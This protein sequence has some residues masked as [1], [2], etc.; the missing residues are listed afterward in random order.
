MILL[1]RSFVQLGARDNPGDFTKSAVAA[2]TDRSRKTSPNWGFRVRY[3]RL[4]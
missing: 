4:R 1:P 2:G 3:R